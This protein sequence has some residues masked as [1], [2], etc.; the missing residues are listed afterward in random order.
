MSDT[1]EARVDTAL[2]SLERLAEAEMELATGDQQLL[3]R[4]NETALQQLKKLSA[5]TQQLQQTSSTL[6]DQ[7]RT[8]PRTHE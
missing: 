1:V 3:T 4:I 8:S 6:V 7:G 5:G 2:R